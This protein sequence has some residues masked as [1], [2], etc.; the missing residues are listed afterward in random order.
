MHQMHRLTYNEDCYN[1]YMLQSTHRNINTSPTSP[2][3]TPPPDPPLHAPGQAHFVRTL[4]SCKQCGVSEC[5][6]RHRVLT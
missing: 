5:L 3:A 6:Q 1:Q 4:N 2:A